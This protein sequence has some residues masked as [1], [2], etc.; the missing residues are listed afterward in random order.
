M[1]RKHIR[2]ARK[3][4]PKFPRAPRSGRNKKASQAR[5]RLIRERNKLERDGR[6]ANGVIMPSGAI[7]ADISKQAPNGSY[8]PPLYYTDRDFQCADC[9]ADETWT[10]RQQKWYYEVA[11]GSIYGT[12]KRC[13]ACRKKR[14]DAKSKQKRHMAAMALAKDKK[15]S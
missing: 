3:P 11:K 12:A 4:A 6:I 10:A 2:P 14:R 13:R 8:S 1:G 15:P 5:L 7:A 9:D